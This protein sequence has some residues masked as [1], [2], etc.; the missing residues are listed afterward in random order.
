MT[1][2]ETIRQL[3]ADARRLLSGTWEPEQ[4]ETICEHAED[5]AETLG[6]PRHGSLAEALLGFAAYLSAFTESSVGPVDA[7]RVQLEALLEAVGEQLQRLETSTALE[8]DAPAPEPEPV[9]ATV[10][11]A[12]DAPAS[13]A[14]PDT[15]VFIDPSGRDAGALGLELEEFGYQVQ[16]LLRLDRQTAHWLNQP[17]V[18]GLILPIA[19]LDIW[20]KLVQIDP[21][22][23][24]AR[25][26]I[27]LFVV[28][29]SDDPRLRLRAS[30]S[31]CDG[32]FVLP[33]A[34]D[35]LAREIVEV[36]RDRLDPY[37]A[38]VID[39]DYSMTMV[40]E[41][42]L[43]RSG[44]DTRVVTDP[45]A[46]L[47][48]LDD[49]LPDVILLDLHMPGLNGLELLSLF[50]AHPKTAFT[51]VVLISGD[52]DQERRFQTLT[53]GGDDYLLKPLR[54]KHL[55]AAVTGRAQRSR[56]LRRALRHSTTPIPLP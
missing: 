48:V 22:L 21:S 39:D 32:Y 42:V 52:E 3:L 41:S 40:V 13:P 15:I 31:G 26:R 33:G 54:P 18:K 47:T 14:L 11:D 55:V 25:R 35:A 24:Q 4:A 2:V 20:E 1:D 27:G 8:L 17:Q 37:R 28:T 6:D 7:K 9:V 10:A 23:D 43:K 49:F 34:T 44:M 36:L 5:Y 56:W 19:G 50:R 29:R 46:A 12:S 38:L 51:P 30:Q 45:T 16:P 53:A